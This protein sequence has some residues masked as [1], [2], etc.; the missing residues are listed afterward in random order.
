M[1]NIAAA[2]MDTAVEHELTAYGL[3]NDGV[4]TFD[5]PYPL[6]LGS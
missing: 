2:G 5:H 1:A 4:D 3:Y 6:D